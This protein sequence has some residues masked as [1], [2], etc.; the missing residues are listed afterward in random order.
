MNAVAELF[1]YDSSDTVVDWKA[2]VS[3]QRCPYLGKRCYKVRKS[4]PQ[5][6]IGSCTV[7]HGRSEAPILIV[8]RV[9][10]NA[11]R[12]SSTACTC[13]RLMSPAMNYTLFRRLQ[14]PAEV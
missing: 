3:N 4:D 9:C 2:V 13:S 8:R 1:G 5:T 11:A 14:F 12:C 7:L 6:S 10:W